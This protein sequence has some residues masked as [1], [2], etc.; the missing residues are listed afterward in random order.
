MHRRVPFVIRLTARTSTESEVEGV[1]IGIDPG[2]THTGVAVF[3]E[4]SGERR[5]RFALQITHRGGQI[6]AN[7]AKRS[8]HRR[9]RRS[10]NLRYRSPRFANRTRSEG[11]LAPSLA[12]RVET[13]LTW[14]ERLARWAPLRQA[15]V[16]RVAFDVHALAAGKPLNGVEYQQGTLAGYEVREYLLATWNRACAYCGT[17]GVP[18]NIDHIH[19]RSQGGSGRIA[20]LALACVGCNQAKSHHPIEEF[21]ACQPARLATILTQA[22]SPLRNAAAVNAT[23]EALWRGL[24]ARLPTRVGSGGRTKYNRTRAS[25]PKTHTQ[26]ALAVGTLDTITTHPAWVMVVGCTGRGG[27]ARTRSDRY[28]FPRLRLPRVKAFFGFQTGD[29]VRAVVP[30]GK[31]TGT[32]VGRVAVR[33]TGSF[34][35]ATAQGTVQGIRHKHVR[36]LQ[37][38]DGYTHTRKEEGVSSPT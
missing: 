2:S 4:S 20:N 37:R 22:K 35:I 16:E 36:L 29:L 18:L 3:T 27:Y 14:V 38:A 26:D 34:N 10:A 12:H 15:H 5:G 25:L 9:R 32:Y 21:L 17:S 31:K 33:A 24:N 8:A 7:L 30:T 28:G 13:T 6:R 11:W 19:P 23:R 1:E